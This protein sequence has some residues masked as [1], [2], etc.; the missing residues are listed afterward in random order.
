MKRREFAAMLN[1]SVRTVDRMIAAR[2]IPVR[3]VRDKTVRI[4]LSD[5]E[6]YLATTAT[7]TGGGQ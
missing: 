6:R 2:E 4:L 7:N 1:V 5:A 3:R